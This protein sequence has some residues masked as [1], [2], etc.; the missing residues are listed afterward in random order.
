MDFPV[1]REHISRMSVY[2]ELMFD[3]ITAIVDGY[4][5]GILRN[6]SG[7]AA[8]IENSNYFIDTDMGRFVLT[9]F[10]RMD[11]TALPWF[12][13]LM[14]HLSAQG[15]PCPAVQQQDNG[16]LLF[17]Y[18]E[19]SQEEKWGCIVS[20]LPGK[21]MDQLSIVQLASAGTTLAQLHMVG[22]GFAP[23]RDNPTGDNWLCQTA[24]QVRAG[25]QERYGDVTVEL[26]DDELAWQSKQVWDALP[27]GVIH[28]DYFCDNILFEGDSLSG[29]IDFY[30]A[31]NA[32]FSMDIAISINAL[33]ICFQQDDDARSAAFLRGYDQ[34][35]PLTTGEVRALPGLLRL[36]ALRFWLSRLF[37][38]VFP[39]PGA[40]TQVKDPEEYRRKLMIHR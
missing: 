23:S 36:S 26:L 31:H 27:C 30:Y 35:R 8:G 11:G 19:S 13:R 1:E 2:T 20:C 16:D 28:G 32:P 24:R 38:A 4:N 33:A 9:I 29:V 21:V 39:R 14:R 17:R 34:I 18:G 6:Y 25:V 10:E 7:I 40:M 15:L 22:S 12:M 3:E 5:L 37:D